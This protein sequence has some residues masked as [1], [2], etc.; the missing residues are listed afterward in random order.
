MVNRM[1]KKNQYMLEHQDLK[2][3]G[4][5]WWWHSFT[6]YSEETGEPKSF[7][8]EYFVM[9]PGLGSDIPI[10]GQLKENDKPS[11]AMVMAGTWEEGKKQIH[12]MYPM[13][14]F[15]YRHEPFR[16]QIGDNI[17]EDVFLAGSVRM[18]KEETKTHP[19]YMSDY[20]SMDW[21]LMVYKEL[22]FDVGYGSSN[23]LRDQNAFNMYWHVEG[24]KTE[25]DGYVNLD[26]KRYLVTKGKSF[27]YQ[28]KNW[29]RDFTN[30]WI[31]LNCNKLSYKGSEEVL[32]Q[33]AFVFGGGQPLVF[34]KA[35]DGKILGVFVHKGKAYEYNF[36]KVW[37]NNRQSFKT[38][39]DGENLHWFIKCQNNHSRIALH[40][41]APKKDLLLMKYENPRGEMNHRHLYNGGTARGEVRLYDKKGKGYQLVGE[42]SGSLAGCEYGTY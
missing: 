22:S 21:S 19:E 13:S 2:D 37:K 3:N 23:F 26:G 6:G 28:D 10:L 24:L 15:T 7:F 16:V 32:E 36:S 17:L 38:K 12:N 14:S 4:F 35:L 1:N 25:Y 11:Y 42:F 31:W 5:D 30:P 34:G 18:S 8:I 20:G 41:Q 9:N 39:D 29:G 40:F 27:G 33:T